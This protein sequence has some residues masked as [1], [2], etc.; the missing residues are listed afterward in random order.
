MTGVATLLGY[1]AGGACRARKV[2]SWG[3]APVK[4]AQSRQLSHDSSVMTAQ[5]RRSEVLVDA[6]RGAVSRRV[7]L[8]QVAELVGEPQAAAIPGGQDRGQPPGQRRGDVAL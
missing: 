6:D 4:T 8:D 2:W 5:S 7:D 1:V 3:P